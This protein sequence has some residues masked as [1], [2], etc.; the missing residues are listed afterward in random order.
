MDKEFG[1][2]RGASVERVRF[3]AGVGPVVVLLCWSVVRVDPPGLD[4]AKKCLGIQYM[5]RTEH[6]RT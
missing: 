1:L 4:G 3:T 2:D 5:L 6:R